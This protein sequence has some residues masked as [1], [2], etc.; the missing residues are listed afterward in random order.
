M[1]FSMKLMCCVFLVIEIMWSF[2]LVC[3]LVMWLCRC[4][5]IFVLM[6]GMF[7]VL[8]CGLMLCLFGVIGLFL[9]LKFILVQVGLGVGCIF[10]IERLV[11][12]CVVYER[13]VFFV[14][15]KCLILLLICQDFFVGMLCFGGYC[16][17]LG[18][19]V[20][21]MVVQFIVL[22]WKVLCCMSFSLFWV[23]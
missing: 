22:F 8:Q 3:M 13:S 18:V 6:N 17:R 5:V 16:I 7:L 12:C 15:W 9:V 1:V 14:V 11:V 10:L 2:E 19:W 4:R 21:F 20:V 23:F